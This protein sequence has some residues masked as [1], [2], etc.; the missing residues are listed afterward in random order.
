MYFIIENPQWNEK[1][2]DYKGSEL[3]NRECVILGK[4]LL[5]AIK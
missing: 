1:W 4:S 5:L 2:C 3:R